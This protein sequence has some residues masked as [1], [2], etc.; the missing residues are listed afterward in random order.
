MYTVF[1][2]REWGLAVTASSEEPKD[3][4]HPDATV[5]GMFVLLC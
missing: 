1:R 5:P 3:E 4:M 2:Y